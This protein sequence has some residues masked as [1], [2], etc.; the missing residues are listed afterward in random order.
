MPLCGPSGSVSNLRSTDAIGALWT[1]MFIYTRINLGVWRLI[2]WPMT[3][4]NQPFGKKAG[5]QYIWDLKALNQSSPRAAF[6]WAVMMTSLAGLPPVY[7]FLGKAGIIWSR[8][9]NNL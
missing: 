1:H 3:R 5:P 4:P 6:R 9:N 7:G 8:L 2:M